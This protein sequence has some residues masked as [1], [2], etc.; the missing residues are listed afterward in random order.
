[1]PNCEQCSAEYVPKSWK[2]TKFCSRE[3]YKRW[4]TEVYLPNYRGE[5]KA[6]SFT[7]QE[8]GIVGVQKGQGNHRRFCST[9]CRRKE[10]LRYG[11]RWRAQPGNRA[12]MRIAEKKWSSRNP[13]RRRNIRLKCDYGLTPQQDIA[14]GPSCRICGITLAKGHGANM[15]SIDHDHATGK[16]RGVLCIKCNAGL[17]Y[18]RDNP[19]LLLEAI[20]YLARH[21]SKE[22][23]FTA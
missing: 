12:K 16:V 1:M 8:C 6:R 11:A 20:Q 15:R 5:I 19:A 2:Q 3:C 13:E 23:E 14:L 4:T 21:T 17:G 10:I 7:C 22:I 9:E 18:F